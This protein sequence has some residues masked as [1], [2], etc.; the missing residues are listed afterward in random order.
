[1]TMHSVESSMIAAVGWDNVSGLVVKF[2]NGNEYQY[3][4]V[5]EHVF[6]ELRSSVSVGKFF[7]SSIQGKYESVKL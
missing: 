2:K 1:M 6:Q 3:S 7:K 4:G 5:P